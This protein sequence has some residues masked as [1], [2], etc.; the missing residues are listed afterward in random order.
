MKKMKD[1]M[2]DTSCSFILICSFMTQGNEK[3]QKSFL[4]INFLFEIFENSLLEVIKALYF[5]L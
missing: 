1:A 5:C 2:H 4:V 3:H